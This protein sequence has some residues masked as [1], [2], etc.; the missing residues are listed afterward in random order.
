MQLQTES[1]AYETAQCVPGFDQDGF[2]L[3]PELWTREMA[4]SLAGDN[5]GRLTDAHWN[6]IE[7]MRDR[8]LRLGALPPMQRVCREL[9]YG[10]DAVRGLFGGCRQL[11][12][13]A[14]LPN[15]G[16]EALTYMD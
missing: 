16:V 1:R 2:L 12:R 13:V 11:W 4:E 10:R 14:G 8:Y 7:F 15:P 5:V 9:G 3:S 6:I